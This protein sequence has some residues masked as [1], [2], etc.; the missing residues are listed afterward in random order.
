ML[1][2]RFSKAELAAAA[3]AA[4]EDD[5]DGALSGGGAY[6]DEEDDRSRS[7]PPYGAFTL[8]DAGGG[9]RG[10]ET[11]DEDGGCAEPS[12]GR[13]DLSALADACATLPTRNSF[14]RDLSPPPP[15]PP[16]E[17]EPAQDLIVRT[18]ICVIPVASHPLR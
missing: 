15:L 2:L 4:D 10:G 7:P 17:P 3:A 5:A 9:A 18:L 1:K 14:L 16:R 12:R 13:R 8:R 6:S 11:E